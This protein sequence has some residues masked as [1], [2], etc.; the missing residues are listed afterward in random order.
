[1]K[2]IN[3]GKFEILNFKLFNKFKIDFQFWLSSE[4]TNVVGDYA[5]LRLLVWKKTKYGYTSKYIYKNY[6]VFR[7]KSKT[8]IV[9]NIKK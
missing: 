6:N 4:C 9:R 1:M 5:R 8:T 2:V 7:L 3:D